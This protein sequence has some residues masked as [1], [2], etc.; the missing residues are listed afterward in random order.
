MS[1]PWTL[2]RVTARAQNHTL[3]NL[4]AN[5]ELQTKTVRCCFNEN[6]EEKTL[7]TSSVS[8]AVGQA[9]SPPLLVRASGDIPGA[10]ASTFYVWNVPT[11]C[12]S[13]CQFHPPVW[14]WSNGS[15][16]AVWNLRLSQEGCDGK[17]IFTVTRGFICLLSLILLWAYTVEFL[18]A[19]HMGYYHMNKK[20][21]WE[22]VVY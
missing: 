5:K 3:W 7:K 22:S 9:S 18:E 19:T 17:P 2:R 16:S 20:Q 15:Q 8:K 13:D 14:P 4:G 21:M 11:L 12:S 6:S 1:S 10:P